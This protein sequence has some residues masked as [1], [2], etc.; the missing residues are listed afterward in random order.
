MSEPLPWIDVKDLLE[1]TGVRNLVHSANEW[2]FSCFSEAHAHGDSSPSAG[3]NGTTTLWRCRNPSCGLKGNAADFLAALKGYTRSE[4]MRILSERYGGP[5]I[6]AEPGA[7]EDELERIRASYAGG[8]GPERKL[9]TEDT[10]LDRYAIHWP[11]GAG[12]GDI[13]DPMAY[14]FGRGFSSATLN[15]WGIGYDDRTDR[16]TIPVRDAAGG[17]VGVKARAWRDDVVPKYLALG[18]P[19]GADY[20]RFGFNTYPKSE[21]VFGLDR[22]Q[23]TDEFVICEGELNVIA[24]KQLGITA[25]AVAGAEFSDQQRDLIVRAASA[26]TIYFDDDPA[27][28]AGAIKVADELLDYMPVSIIVAPGDAAD[29]LNPLKSFSPDDLH[30]AHDLS[31]SA[32]EHFALRYNQS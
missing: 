32:F 5:D 3:M 21:H 15:D 25:V 31:P 18:D 4:S 1:A 26:V 10:Y 17:I 29:A 28:E 12:W 13:P 30:L 27:G 20:V 2:S 19:P 6:S 8:D 22:V 11:V 16:V 9:I 23:D 24:L 14:M 7:L